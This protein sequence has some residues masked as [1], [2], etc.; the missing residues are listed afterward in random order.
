MLDSRR[1]ND[2]L[3]TN[4]EY[5]V[6]DHFLLITTSGDLLAYPR[7]TDIKQYRDEAA[8]VV[9]AWKDSDQLLMNKYN[10]KL[11]S[12]R[13]RSAHIADKELQA[14]TI[15]AQKGNIIVYAIQ[16][17]LLL[18]LVGA[19][20]P[21]SNSTEVEFIHEA[22]GEAR[23]PPRS[24]EPHLHVLDFSSPEMDL[25]ATPPAQFGNQIDTQLDPGSQG[26][27]PSATPPYEEPNPMSISQQSLNIPIEQQHL[28]ILHLQRSKLERMADHL[29]KEMDVTIGKELA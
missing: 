9:K 24:D 6:I 19:K 20:T 7:P 8:L 14:L 10:R 13:N 25:P 4:V 28:G 27:S 26:Q 17:R 1:L 12:T 2:W 18:V 15:S 3:Q 29:A 23:Y 11:P 16:P 21:P 22:K 5:P